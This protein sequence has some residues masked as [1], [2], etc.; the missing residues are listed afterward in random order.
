MNCHRTVGGTV[1]G[2]SP[3]AAN[4]LA[5]PG[6]LSACFHLIGPASPLRTRGIPTWKRQSVVAGT[7]ARPVEGRWLLSFEDQNLK[8]GVRNLFTH[9]RKLF[10]TAADNEG[11]YR[12]RSGGR[13]VWSNGTLGRSASE[14][15]H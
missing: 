15:I 8:V 7:G 4:A 2:F 14:R 12:K 10:S 9:C 3:Q 1:L 6:L 5:I 13:M 11:F